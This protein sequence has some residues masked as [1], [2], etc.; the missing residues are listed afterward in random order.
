[1]REPG[2]YDFL[3]KILREHVAD[4]RARADGFYCLIEMRRDRAALA[5]GCLATLLAHREGRPK[6][7]VCVLPDDALA[8]MICW[9]GRLNREVRRLAGRSDA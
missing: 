6:P 2:H 9:E 3:E 7:A 8:D 4:E 1:M 5:M